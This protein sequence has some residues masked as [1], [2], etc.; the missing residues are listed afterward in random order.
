MPMRV[1]SAHVVRRTLAIAFATLLCAVPSSARA[2][3]T[4]PHADITRDALLSEG[5][6]PASASITA[7]NNWF[8]DYYT[9]PDKNPYSGHASFLIG[10][11]RLGL[12]RENWPQSWVDAARKLHFDSES[13]FPAMPNLSTTAGVEREWQ[14]L[15]YLTQRW[16]RYAKEKND[17]VRVLTVIGTSLH[18]VQDFYSHSNWVEDPALVNGKSFG[19]GGPRTA[20]RRY[21]DTPTWFDVPPEA[22][23]A[24]VGDLAVFTGVKGIPRGHGNW[25]SGDNKTLSNGL[26]KDWSGRPKYQEAYITAYFATRQWI[27]AIRT[28]LGNEPLW[29]RAM[30]MPN[31]RELAHDVKGAT[32]ISEFSGHWDGGG[33]P[34][35]PFSCGQRTGKAG[36][37]VSLRLALG[38]YHD[39]G[40][41]RYRRAFNEL[42]PEWG[43]YPTG[44]PNYPDLPSS[45][46]DQVFTRFVK[47]EVLDYKGFDLGDPIGE[48]DIYAN[49]RIRGQPYTSTVINGEQSFSFPGVYQPFTWIRSVP[50]TNR[51]STPVTSMTVRIETG[52]RAFAGTDDDVYLRINGNQRFSLDKAA[53]NDFE[54]GDNDTYSVP[55]GS[56]TRDG[57]T[58][59]DIDRVAIEKSRDGIAGGWFLHGVTLVVNGQVL[60]SN[61]PIDRWL[62]KSNRVWVA[63]G[64]V[65]DNRT[66]D[67]VGAWLQLRD[68]DFGNNDTGDV[69]EYDRHTSAPIAYRLGPPLQ[70]RVLGGARLRGR[71]S[72][73]NG[74]SARLTYRLTTLAVVPPPE[75]VPPPTGPGPSPPPPTNPPT[76]GGPDLI[77]SSFTGDQFTVKNQGATDAGPFRVRVSSSPTGDTNYD[78]TGLAVGQTETRS[79]A[80]PCEEARDAYADS[81]NQVG[82][83]N[84]ENNTAHFQNSI[85]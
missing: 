35:V 55:I 18:A 5:A 81:L 74:D 17:P 45:R 19:Y 49:A 61:R 23:R 10:V 68:D 16:L 1:A 4:G 6:S 7:V 60:V 58:V 57:L 66:D 20:L 41:T 67:V 70:R 42:I 26:N 29:N 40:P 33:E 31:T 48:A 59:G 34:C 80:R 24:L 21:G 71:L 37:V 76:P 32:E 30:S 83:S 62:E 50:T 82:E 54:R 3:D 64:L 78:F 79:Y 46:T 75:P 84:E 22:R 38:D 85:C 14:R 52:N 63:P 2:F 65:R 8:V 43:K 39:R 15:M 13:R 12:A 77:I 56:A 47:L 36:S 69:N 27:R 51:E 53:Y 25:R 73:E 44:T 9:N 11:T 28:W 72:L